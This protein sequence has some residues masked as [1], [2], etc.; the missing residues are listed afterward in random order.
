LKD[1]I[2][3]AGNLL[4]ARKGSYHWKSFDDKFEIGFDLVVMS[5]LIDLVVIF[6]F[7]SAGGDFLSYLFET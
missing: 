7:L 4:R 5:V 6:F 1:S 2:T 3:W